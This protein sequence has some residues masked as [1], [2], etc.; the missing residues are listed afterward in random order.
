MQVPEGSLFR[1]D[2][3]WGVYLVE[4]GRAQR[5]AVRVGRR[6]GLKAQVLDGVQPG[7]RVVL[8][9]PDSVQDGVLVEPR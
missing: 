5:R 6:N 9:P 1:L 4:D 7:D 2:E 8:H 3:G